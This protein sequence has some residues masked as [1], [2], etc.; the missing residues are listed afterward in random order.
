MKHITELPGN[1]VILACSGGVDSIVLLHLLKKIDK[2]RI[3]IAHL[4]HS[5]RKESSEDLEFVKDLAIKEGYEFISKRLENAPKNEEEARVSRYKFLSKCL[6]QYQAS[7]IALAQH[8]SDQIE[9]LLLQLIRGTHSFSPM[10]VLSSDNKW[11]P[12]LEYTKEEILRYAQTN[13]LKWREDNS[14]TDNKY[15]RNRLRNLVIPEIQK[16]NPNFAQRFLEFVTQVKSM[17]EISIKELSKI[18][19]SNNIKRD[20]FLALSEMAQQTLIKKLAPELYSKHIKEVIEL[21]NK[22]IGNKQKH[23]FHLNKGEIVYNKPSID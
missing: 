14:N 5:I 2:K 15:A 12:L 22:G 3:V 19:I 17:S 20:D 9:T 11:R 21:I 4:D 13:N 18:D 16:I 6:K 10:K 1:R 23:N 7:H 8:Q